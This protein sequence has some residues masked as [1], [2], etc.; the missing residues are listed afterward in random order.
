MNMQMWFSALLAA[1]ISTSAGA[2]EGKLRYQEYVEAQSRALADRGMRER[3]EEAR[4]YEEGRPAREAQLR[5]DE[6]H[7]L[8]NEAEVKKQAIREAEAKKKGAIRE[9]EAK[10]KGAERALQ[11]LPKA[12]QALSGDKFCAAFGNALR[13]DSKAVAAVAHTE[14][15]RRNLSFNSAAAIAQE[16]KMG[17]SECQLY[18]AW[19]FPD[20]QNRSVGSWG[21]HT[22]HVYRDFGTYV[23][24]ENGRVTSWQD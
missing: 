24:T 8:H 19:G 10:K 4:I 13:G 5:E 1:T 11:A 9:A 18:A 21:V 22:Q 15:K 2:S 17:E 6:E 12:L 14:A 20:S 16:F 7:R 23:Y 3:E